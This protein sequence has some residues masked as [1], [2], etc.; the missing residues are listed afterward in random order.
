MEESTVIETSILTRN[1]NLSDK[2][3]QSKKVNNVITSIGES[4][5]YRNSISKTDQSTSEESLDLSIGDSYKRNLST[6][7]NETLSSDYSRR[8]FEPM[9]VI[10][11]N[12]IYALY[13]QPI[14]EDVNYFK[15]TQ[16]WVG[17]IIGIN[18]KGF[19]ARLED[20]NNPGTFEVADFDLEEVSQEDQK[21]ISEGSIF[22]WSVGFAVRS[23]GQVI[24]ESLLR[25]Q[26]LPPWNVEE[27]DR[28]ADSSSK[29]RGRLKWE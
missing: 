17:H 9:N 25:F 4:L 5:N 26:R 29:L 18:A 10:Y 28:I 20:L 12:R 14:S 16:N 11:D 6:E 21:L 13:K 2:P 22:Y 27:F 1:Y 19:V 23:G 7:N 15:H 24:K 3:L 8:F